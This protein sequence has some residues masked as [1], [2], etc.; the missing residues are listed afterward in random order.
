[1]TCGPWKDVMIED[2]RPSAIS[3]LVLPR[4]SHGAGWGCGGRSVWARATARVF[5]GF[6]RVKGD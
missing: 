6:P 5:L 4:V 2:G 3:S 1:M